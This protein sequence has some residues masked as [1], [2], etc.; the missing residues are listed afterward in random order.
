MIVN[1]I[2]TM[3]LG[4]V[5]VSVNWVNICTDLGIIAKKASSP[6]RLNK[7][8]GYLWLTIVLVAKH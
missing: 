6:G 3:I 5:K 8:A 1:E 7:I 4:L 2:Q